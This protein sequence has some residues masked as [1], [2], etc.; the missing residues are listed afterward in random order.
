MA[1][2]RARYGTYH[3]ILGFEDEE[4]EAAEVAQL[5]KDLQLLA[6]EKLTLEA[7]EKLQEADQ[8]LG[9]A[10]KEAHALIDEL[11]AEGLE[12]DAN[13]VERLM[14]ILEDGLRTTTMRMTATTMTR[15]TA[16]RR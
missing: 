1:A 4:T 16:R 10:I 11:R 13:E 6:K 3:H 7:A 9:E 14:K 8:D 12:E 5:A 15:I 2:L